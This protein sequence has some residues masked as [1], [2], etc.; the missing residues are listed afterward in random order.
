MSKTFISH[1]NDAG[2]VINNLKK[3]CNELWGNVLGRGISTF[4]LLLPHL[5]Q[6]RM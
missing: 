6:V 3:W 2:N 5:A 1:K 4:A